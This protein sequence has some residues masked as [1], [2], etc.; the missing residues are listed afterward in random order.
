MHAF[1][2]EQY[3]SRFLTT[4]FAH[5]DVDVDTVWLADKTVP[6]IKHSRTHALAMLNASVSVPTFL[7]KNGNTVLWLK[8]QYRAYRNLV[9]SSKDAY[10]CYE[11]HLVGRAAENIILIGS[12][13]QCKTWPGWN[14]L[15]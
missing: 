3:Y 4:S 11:L 6:P 8:V 1:Q 15:P 14:C 12:W 5:G 13:S 10:V 7:F 9:S 2:V